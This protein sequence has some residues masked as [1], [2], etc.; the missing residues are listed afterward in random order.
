V[1]HAIFKRNNKLWFEIQIKSWT[2]V[3]IKC[4]I[5]IWL[6]EQ[7]LCWEHCDWRSIMRYVFMLNDEVSAWM[8]KK[9]HISTLTTEAEYI[10]LEHDVRQ[11]VWM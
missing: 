2:F 9:Q 5:Y 3:Q 4:K 6:C 1:S 7:Q 8:S 11:E 10:A